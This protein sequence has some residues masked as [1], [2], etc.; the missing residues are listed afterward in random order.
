MTEVEVWWFVGAVYISSRDRYKAP[1][2]AHSD[3]VN[4]FLAL[5]KTG[6]AN[7][8]TFLFFDGLIAVIYGKRNNRRRSRLLTPSF[9]LVRVEV[10]SIYTLWIAV[11]KCYLD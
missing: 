8:Y 1:K 3:D 11:S 9:G 6:N 10:L 5:H 2:M 4:L 7:F